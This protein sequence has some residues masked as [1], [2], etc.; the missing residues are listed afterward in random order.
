MLTISPNVGIYQSNNNINQNQSHG[1]YK[2][3]SPMPFDSVSFKGT[4]FSEGNR[5]MGRKI[6]KAI[7]DHDKF[8]VLVH[9]NSDMDAL[10]GEL[11]LKRYIESIPGK[12]CDIFTEQPL[13]HN[14]KFID[15]HGEIK[16]VRKNATAESLRKQFG[17]YDVAI[18]FDTAETKLH[19][20]RLFDA[21]FKTAKVTADIDHHPKSGGEFANIT[22]VDTSKKSGTLVLLEFFRSFFGGRKN[23]T[24]AI[25]DP[26]SAGAIGDTER[27]SKITPEVIKDLTILSKTSN[28]GEILKRMTRMTRPELKVYNEALDSVVFSKGQTIAHFQIDLKGRK[29]N[30]HKVVGDVM[31]TL[32]QVNSV[33][34][35]FGIIHDSTDPKAGIRAS[36]RS[37]KEPIRQAIQ[38]LGGG[39][40]DTAC[41]LFKRKEE[42]NPKKLERAL[43]RA[44]AA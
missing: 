26:I 3:I 32:G 31:F 2:K 17:T 4:W 6:V 5:F 13:Q 8:A 36:V 40:H 10:G 16:V 41:G 7:K 18:S 23:M 12:V 28:L 15:P 33:Q 37:H 29:V 24:R 1:G 20:P 27:L 22:L 14:Y 35:Y 43:V 9:R 34:K 19:D 21:F 30:P 25:S 38:K 39:G 42:T 44:L 11:A